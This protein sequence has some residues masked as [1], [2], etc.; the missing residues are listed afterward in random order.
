MS[1][2]I[3]TGANSG[4]GLATAK[5]LAENHQLIWLCRS[6]SKAEVARKK[7]TDTLPDANIDI[8]E[9]DLSSQSSIESASQK[10]YE[11]YDSIDVLINNAG[12]M[13]YPKRTETP[14]GIE[15]TIA[16]NH[17][18]PLL[19]TLLIKNLLKNARN[20]GRVI[21]VNSY[22][23]RHGK[24]DWENVQ[25][26]ENYRPMKA[27]ALSKLMALT[28]SNKLSELLKDDK[29][30]VNSIDPGMVYTGIDRTYSNW[31]QMMYR[32]GKPFMKSAEKGAETSIYLAEE[33]QGLNAT[34]ELF[35]DKKT[36]KPSSK[37]TDRN[38]QNQIWEWSLKKL[39][40]KTSLL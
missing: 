34:G 8:I 33:E 36:I 2:I 39:Q 37:T 26:E 30:S 9:C 19:L 25:L 3:I 20:G 40:T 22:M 38:L 16:T 17:L 29:I 14:E 31:F 24:L 18:G 1:R 12:F 35:K 6:T 15:A 13:G 27:Y 28:I 21:N 11:R 10:I 4:I 23:H 7:I 32:L 5:F